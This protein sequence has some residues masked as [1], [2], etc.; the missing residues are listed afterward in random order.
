[1]AHLRTHGAAQG[2]GRSSKLREA[3]WS[4]NLVR[5]VLARL[6]RG[7]LV[8]MTWLNHSSVQA[9]RSAEVD[10][11]PLT[12]VGVDGT[13]LQGILGGH[14]PR[15]SADLVVPLLLDGMDGSPRVGL[16]GSRPEQ[17]QRAAARLAEYSSS[18][19][20]VFLQDGYD[21]RMEPP[22][23]VEHLQGLDLDVLV[24]GLGAPLQD[25]Y[26]TALAAAERRPRVVLT[27]GGW[28]EQVTHRSYYPRFAYKLKLNWLVRLVREPRRLWRRYT[29]SAARAVLHRRDLKHYVSDRAGGAFD[30]GRT[31]AA[32]R[33]RGPAGR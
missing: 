3:D 21:G 25:V 24:I 2:R 20:V 17:L 9:C 7:E 18:P 11:T 16:L 28:L 5:D 33:P 23:L 30:R 1:M 4:A 22:E 26:V 14:P 6:R 12:Y 29:V 32:G 13:L 31:A 27:C 10:L 8:T 19:R 15:T